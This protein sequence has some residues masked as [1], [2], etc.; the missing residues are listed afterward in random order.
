MTASADLVIT[1]AA[2]WTGDP[3]RSA[4]AIALRGD[5]I[6]AVGSEES[7]ATPPRSSRSSG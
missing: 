7:I 1:G 5:R 6:V 4:S 3:A 2:V